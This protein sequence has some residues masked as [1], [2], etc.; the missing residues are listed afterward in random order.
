MEVD[1]LKYYEQLLDLQ[2]FSR[3]DVVRLTGSAAAANSLINSYKHKGYIESVRRDLYVAISLETKQ[4]V[5]NRYRI[6]SNVTDGAYVS[7][8]S[9][10]EFYG[11]ANQV[12]YEVYVSGAGRFAPFEYDE[13]SYRYIAPRIEAG[14]ITN[15]GV[16]VTDNERTILDSINDFER[17][18]GLEE[19][20]R[21]LELIPSVDEERLLT[22]LSLYN[23][24]FL[25]QKAGYILRHY[26][27]ALR[28][29]DRFFDICEKNCSKSVRYLYSGI[30]HETN[31]FDGRWKLVVPKDLNK[32]TSKGVDA[33]ADV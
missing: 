3:E 15:N 9:A 7:H 27:K 14:I 19:L 17:I 12:F 13:V 8:H 31:S 4:A 28:L 26:Q 2:C 24:R 20:L 25:Y 21:C 33:D 1:V 6:A 5:A 22:Y 30:E 10:F 11:C 29:L 16:R 32:L 23:K 18:A